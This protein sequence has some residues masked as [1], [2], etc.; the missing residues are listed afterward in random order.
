MVTA[1]NRGWSAKCQVE[2]LVVDVEVGPTAVGISW[3]FNMNILHAPTTSGAFSAQ[4]SADAA[5]A[6][7]RFTGSLS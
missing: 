3:A 5:D 4:V 6:L 7:Q 1:H 2:L